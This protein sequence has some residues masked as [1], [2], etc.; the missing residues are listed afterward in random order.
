[1]SAD[2][3]S[4]HADMLRNNIVSI[5]IFKLYQ[6]KQISEYFRLKTFFLLL[7]L[8]KSKQKSAFRRQSA[9]GRPPLELAPIPSLRSE[10]ETPTQASNGFAD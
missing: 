4:H 7:F 3:I 8:E 1:V 9:F 6:N 2:A 5:F 10:W